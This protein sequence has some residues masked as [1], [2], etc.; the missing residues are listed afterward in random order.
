MLPV[1]LLTLS[2]EQSWNV[3]WALQTAWYLVTLVMLASMW[4]LSRATKAP[5][6]GTGWIVLATVFALLATCSSIQ[7][8]AVWPAGTVF[9]LASAGTSA[10]NALS[11][12]RLPVWLALAF[13]GLAFYGWIFSLTPTRHSSSNDILA[14][15]SAEPLAVTRFAPGV[16]SAVWGDHLG[17]RAV[18]AGI[19]VVAICVGAVAHALCS[20][21]RQQLAMPLAL[22]AFGAGFAAMVVAGRFRFGEHAALESRH[23]AYV[24]LALAG[25]VLIWLQPTVGTL[26]RSIASGMRVVLAL[27]VVAMFVSPAAQ[28]NKAGRSW[29]L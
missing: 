22:L 4:F 19:V 10:C 24:L 17:D 3:L 1:V 26:A 13:V 23:S 11:D 12:R 18:P 9:P 8:L 6:P 27:L 15:L 14:A 28:A 25:A 21:G 2:L 29:R 5:C 20:K 16:A 7:G